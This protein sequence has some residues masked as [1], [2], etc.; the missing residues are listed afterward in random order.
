MSA[1]HYR[2]VSA[3]PTGTAL[4]RY[5]M[6]LG[7]GRN[8]MW[9]ELTLAEKFTDSPQVHATLELRTKAAVAA[10]TT[11]DATWAG[12]LAVYGIAQEALTLLRGASIIGALESKMR[13]VPFR[14][15]VPRET[16]SGT[17]GAW[18]GEG[19][20]TPVA[21]TAYDTLSQEAYKGQKIVVLSTDL[22][23][24]GDP[25]AERSVRETVIAGVAAYLDGQF[26][27]N[28][29]TLSANLRPAAIT[30]GATAITSTGSTAAQINAD[31][32]AMLAAITTGGAG[33]VWI[34]RPLTAYKIAATIGGT[35]AA[36]IPRTLFGI[37]LILSANSPQQVTLIDAAHILY[38]DTGGF[39]VDVSEQASI[40]FDDAPTDP[41][42]AATVLRSL[43]QNNLWGIK[44]SRWISYLR[45]Q[46]G[47]VTYM[48]VAY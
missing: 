5:L 27:T 46:T 32:S 8:D 48:T 14:T 39:D 34:M 11:T 41:A 15:K 3:L 26:L 4:S 31:L 24:L 47:A 19:L 28:T 38:S 44:V 12:P 33:L 1:D 21:A 9:T 37:P 7:A 20:S 18:V 36:D 6:V 22:L 30:N 29:V 42:V 25:D 10:G 23:K 17:G 2:V 45:A 40:Q 43:F 16:G 13:R 35:A